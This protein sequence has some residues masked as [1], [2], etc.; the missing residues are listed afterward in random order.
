MNDLREED[1]IMGKKKDVA[2]EKML[3]VRR[4]E[5]CLP[6]DTV[7]AMEGNIIMLSPENEISE[8]ERQV[9]RFLGRRNQGDIIPYGK[10]NLDLY[11]T[12]ESVGFEEIGKTGWL[13]KHITSVYSLDGKIKYEIAEDMDEDDNEWD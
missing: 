10:R 5:I 11:K 3:L 4:L 8:R 12:Y 13:C 1:N 9:N 7:E 6:G 2:Y